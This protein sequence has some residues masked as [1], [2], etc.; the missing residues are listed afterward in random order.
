MKRYLVLFKNTRAVISAERLCRK[1]CIACKI[2]PVPRSISTECGMAIEYQLEDRET[3]GKILDD[4]EL[5]YTLSV[6]E[7]G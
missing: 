7:K 1:H 5:E 6:W 3:I 2:L 4:A